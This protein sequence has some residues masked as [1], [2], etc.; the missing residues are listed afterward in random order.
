MYT[1]SNCVTNSVESTGTTQLLFPRKLSE[2]L[3]FVDRMVMCI[4][5]YV[6]KRPFSTLVAMCFSCF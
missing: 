3:M 5:A 4:L 1:T 6:L 2:F